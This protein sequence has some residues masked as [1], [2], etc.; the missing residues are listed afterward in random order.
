MQS[1]TRPAV[2]ALAAALLAA[3]PADAKTWILV[4]AGKHASAEAAARSEASVRWTDSDLAD[5]TACTEC[6]A[7]TELQHY[8]RKMSGSP[9]DF[10]IVDDDAGP[11]GDWIL[12]GG[13]N[14]NAAALRLAASLGIDPKRLE[15]LGAE[16]YR[17]VSKMAEGRR[18]TAIAGGGR[19]G[20]LYGAYDFLH[21]LGCRWFAPGEVHEEIPHVERIPDL[22][23]AE[24][25]AFHT[26]GFLAWED[27]GSGEFLLWMARNRLND[28]CVEQ[29]NHALLH[30]LGIRLVG[31]LHDAE[32]RFLHPNAPY[33]YNH[34]RW[35][36]DENKPADPY[37]E[38][39]QY[40]GDADGDGKLSYFEA[41]PEW[42]AMVKGQRVPGFKTWSGT[43]Y[44][45]SNAHA[46]TEFMKNFVQ[47]MVDGPYR[48]ADVIRFWTLDAAKWCSC[49]ECQALGIPTDRNLLLVHRLDREIKRARAEGRL[50]RPI[51][52][53][54]LAYADVLQPP[55]RPLPADFDYTTC[56][57]TYY[58]ICRCYVHQF[59]DPGCAVN[60]RYL[61]QLRGWAM[62]P[63]RLF[64]GQLQI[65]EYYN[66]SGYKCLP[67]NFSRTMAH[68]IPYFYKIGARQFE[69]M[70]VTTGLWGTKALTNYQMARQLWS[71][72]ADCRA[73]WD[74]YF[75]RRYGPAAQPMRAFYDELE[76]MLCNVTEIRYG[77]ARRLN[78]GAEELFPTSHL[79]L[80][81]SPG[82]PCDGPTWTE[83]VAHGRECRT[84]IDK[85]LSS[86]LPQRIKARIAEDKRTFTYAERTI[87]YYDACIR[88]LLAARAKR[89]DEARGQHARAKDLAKLLQ[90]DKTSASLSSAHA[91]AANAF[92]ATLAKGALERLGRLVDA[93]A[94]K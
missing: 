32:E 68:D 85:V 67:V 34:P 16:G 72:D 2:F 31:G 53:R 6:F 54:F 49:P 76:K 20:T 52:L 26:R 17:V 94:A 74:D 66:V 63:G 56:W 83:I 1:T 57:A 55:T 75:A 59:D 71:V 77:L 12:V 69:Y 39:G 15:S 18:V 10:A 5:D 47:A 42:F 87:A 37:P 24:R 93:G 88:G 73:L 62:D 70:H 78:Q 4:S 60:A 30:K 7:A 3:L 27:R 40:Q 36:G 79:R 50:Q 43:N 46:T 82:A 14:S 22:D 41:H 51:L 13:P 9:D 64:R 48:D 35:Q 38:S 92:E 90:E 33:P 11:A 65:G 23:V 61:A 84:A 29:A 58:P 28:W 81:R 45:T 44:C 8:L 21:R 89:M 25:P 91:S 19:V 86:S 80:E